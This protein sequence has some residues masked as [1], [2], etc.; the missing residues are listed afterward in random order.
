MILVMKLKEHNTDEDLEHYK[1]SQ[2]IDGNLEYY[3]YRTNT[4]EDLEHHKASQNI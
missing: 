2:N 4:E 3:N 1:A